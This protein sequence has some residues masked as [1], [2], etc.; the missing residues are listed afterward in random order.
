MLVLGG[1]AAAGAAL[2]AVVDMAAAAVG[3]WMDDRGGRFDYVQGE[4]FVRS[5]VT[6]SCC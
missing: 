6:S 3:V 5:F 2:R 1:A 4:L